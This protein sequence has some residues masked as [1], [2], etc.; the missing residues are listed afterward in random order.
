MFPQQSIAVSPL[1]G[2]FV[3]FGTALT[4]QQE[5]FA[6]VYWKTLDT[7]RRPF[8]RK[9]AK[10]AYAILQGCK[11]AVVEALENGDSTPEGVVD[12]NLE[13]L[14]AFF[15]ALHREVGSAFGD[16]SIRAIQRLQ[17]ALFDPQYEPMRDWSKKHSAKQIVG[18]TNSTRGSVRKLVSGALLRGETLD[19]L[20]KSIR[21]VDPAAFSEARAF[22][23]ARTEVVAGSN[24]GLHFGARQQL[25]RNAQN[26]EKGW[27]NSADERVRVSHGITQWVPL[28]QPFKLAAGSLMFPGDS[29]LGADASEIVNCRCTVGYRP[30]K[31]AAPRELPP[32]VPKPSRERGWEKP[33]SAGLWSLDETQGYRRKFQ[34]FRDREDKLVGLLIKDP[35]WQKSVEVFRDAFG[36]S[37][38]TH[39]SKVT[40][41]AVDQFQYAWN[42][43]SFD[44]D[45]FSIMLHLGVE[46]EFGVKAPLFGK[47]PVGVTSFLR[48][49]M[50]AVRAYVRAQY[51]V[52]QDYLAANKVDNLVVFRGIEKA[53]HKLQPGDKAQNVNSV[54]RHLSSWS[55]DYYTAQDFSQAGVYATRFPRE[56]IFS[57]WNT[58]LGVRSESEVVVL[59]GNTPSWFVTVSSSE[60][61]YLDT[62][63]RTVSGKRIVYSNLDAVLTDADW[64][65]RTWGL[66]RS[67]EKFLEV[68]KSLDMTVAGFKTLPVYAFNKD[69]I[70]FLK[71]L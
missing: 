9:Y 5:R 62:V 4:P 27:L 51:K 36:L 58:G 53:P 49:N 41:R 32:Q 61:G 10:L 33:S 55:Y 22:R 14:P 70:A 47:V 17:K 45:K 31:G 57:L 6:D 50:P 11:D 38:Q 39:A 43:S 68:L 1:N 12:S 42:M 71:D 46:A 25:G 18:I 48:D 67:K 19:D 2:V 13:D 34:H 15:D 21:N 3:L 60:K 26:F 66:P 59:A 23:I 65:K 54:T 29:S 52:T 56:R 44:S 30:R 7:Q 16:R 8:E 40:A 35:D 37:L 63:K 28:D 64:P 24:A 69:K 20:A